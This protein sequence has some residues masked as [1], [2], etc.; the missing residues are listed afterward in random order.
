MDNCPEY[1][2]EKNEM[3]LVYHQRELAKAK[4]INRVKTNNTIKYFVHY[5]GWNKAWDEWI[6]SSS[7]LKITEENQKLSEILKENN[8]KCEVKEKP[9]VSH[10]SDFQK[11]FEKKERKVKSI[12]N[13]DVGESIYN[14]L[15]K[16]SV[17]INHDKR[18]IKLPQTDLPTIQDLF[19]DFLIFRF[20]DE[21]A[22][23]S[24][25]NELS[26]TKRLC[27]ITFK[28]DLFNENLTGNL[29]KMSKNFRKSIYIEFICGLKKLF[30]LKA[31]NLIYFYEK[32]QAMQILMNRYSSKK[33]SEI[34]LSKQIVKP[35]DIANEST[36]KEQLNGEY[37]KELEN[38]RKFLCP[39]N[40]YLDEKKDELD[41]CRIFLPINF[42]R[43]LIDSTTYNL[44]EYFAYDSFFTVK[45][46][47]V[48]FEDF[49]NFLEINKQKYFKH[50][51]DEDY[52]NLEANMDHFKNVP[53]DNDNYEEITKSCYLT[54][55]KF[56]KSNTDQNDK[57]EMDQKNQNNDN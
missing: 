52:Y 10:S 53:N 47:H 51:Y 8:V 3:V 12:K 55:Y 16:D 48:L 22:G 15:V 4:I 49:I 41:P 26:R 18:I 40:N 57:S 24:K 46:L 29:Q 34:Y 6:S 37:E 32:P 44:F 39:Y 17:I 25:F 50:V 19:N 27:E 42:V 31:K 43:M 11:P 45:L 36:N 23:N 56:Y 35:L 20:K 14:I 1:E 38:I 7:I 5:S 30:N 28:E 9:V 13:V 21:D 54:L 2:F 33:Y